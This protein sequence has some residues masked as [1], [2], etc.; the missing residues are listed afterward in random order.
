MRPLALPALG[1]A[2]QPQPSKQM[3]ARFAPCPFIPKCTH[4]RRWSWNSQAGNH[5]IRRETVPQSLP[6]VHTV[7]DVL[8]TRVENSFN[9]L[10]SKVSLH[11][12]DNPVCISKRKPMLAGHRD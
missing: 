8:V 2:L 6:R 4:F 7:A 12:K 5:R 10:R 9:V 3:E 1:S 11:R